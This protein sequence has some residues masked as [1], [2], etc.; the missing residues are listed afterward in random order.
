MNAVFD[1]FWRS[2]AYCLHPR[3]IGLSLLPLVLMVGMIAGLGYLFLDTALAAVQ[4]LLESSDLLNSMWAWLESVGVGRLKTVLVPLLVIAGATP[5]IVIACLLVVAT[6]MTPLM[7]RLVTRRRFPLLARSG[8]ASYLVSVVWALGS[9]LMAIAAMVLSLPL[10]LIPPLVLVL[11]PLIWGWLAYRVMAF[12]AL[13]DHASSEERH[14]IFRRH[15]LWLLGMGVITGY[16]GAGPSLIWSLGFVA[17]AM[18]P[19]LVMISVW[20]YTLIFAFSSLWFSHYCLS[21]LQQLRRERAEQAVPPPE[22]LPDPL[23]IL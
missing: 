16:M 18:A 15:R 13:A 11:P 8:G 22:P 3:V 14:A 5:L 7:V 1:A 12:D 10:W 2:V 9:S 4:G 21:A 23:E 17:M 6:L 19:V 20:L